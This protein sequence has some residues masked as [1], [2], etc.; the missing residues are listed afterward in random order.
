MSYLS[1]IDNL[2]DL[3]WNEADDRPYN[4]ITSPR[5]SFA[6]GAEWAAGWIIALTKMG[7]AIAARTC[8]HLT[9]RSRC[10]QCGKTMHEI[11]SARN[12]D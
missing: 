12:G 11:R 3:A 9:L 1:A 2:H 8:R 4:D 5:I 10:A 7:E 6:D